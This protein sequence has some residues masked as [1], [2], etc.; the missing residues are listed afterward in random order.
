M[1]LSYQ[2]IDKVFESCYNEH[3]IMIEQMLIQDVHK[4]E[5]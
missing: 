1:T 3:M 4:G 5:I 2:P